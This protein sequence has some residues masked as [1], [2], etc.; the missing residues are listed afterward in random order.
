MEVNI[1][2]L[3]VLLSYGFSKKIS[4]LALLATNNSIDDA[5][6]WLTEHDDIDEV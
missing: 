5:F 3:N 1:V 2:A 6:D 4:I